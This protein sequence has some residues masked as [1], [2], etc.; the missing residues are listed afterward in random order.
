[1]TNMGQRVL[2]RRAAGGGWRGPLGRKHNI[3]MSEALCHPFYAE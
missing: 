1:M 2:A 3:K